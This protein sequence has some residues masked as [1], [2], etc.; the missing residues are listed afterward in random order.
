MASPP[1]HLFSWPAAE[2]F[3]SGISIHRAEN[4]ARIMKEIGAARRVE[5]PFGGKE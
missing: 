3:G 4:L 5:M 1:R 2:D